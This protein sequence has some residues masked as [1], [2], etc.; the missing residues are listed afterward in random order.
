MTLEI[1]SSVIAASKPKLRRLTID[2][3]DRREWNGPTSTSTY[4]VGPINPIGFGGER[5]F[6]TF[7]DDFSRY[8]EIYTGSKKSNWFKYLKAFHN[9][10]KTRS[11]EEH[12]V[13]RLRSDNGSEQQSKGVDEWLRKEGITFEPSA[14]YSQEQNGVSKRVG[15]NIMDMT[16]ATILE[17]NLNDELWPEIILAMTYVKNVRPTRALQG[18]NP[19]QVQHQ[20]NPDIS[21]L[22]IL[23]STVYVFFIHEKERT[24]KSEKW[25]PRA[26]RGRL[27]GYDGHIYRVHIES[28]NKVIRVILAS[29]MSE[30][31]RL[32]L[33]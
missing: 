3:D 4:S 22:W 13:K 19:Y 7:T 33:C 26:I 10:W 17:G 8:T 29:W 16:R 5:Y 11:K 21:H 1:S 31:Q 24:L 30:W 14:P 9:L 23:G 32:K 2:T 18:N 15:R 28:Q 6:F 27:V 25:A 12:P 20:K